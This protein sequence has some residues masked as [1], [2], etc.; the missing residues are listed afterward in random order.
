M[1]SRF[2]YADILA[3]LGRVFVPGLL[4]GFFRH[5]RMSNVKELIGVCYT[6]RLPAAYVWEDGLDAP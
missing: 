1:S 3:A 4:N 2:V 6:S 5:T